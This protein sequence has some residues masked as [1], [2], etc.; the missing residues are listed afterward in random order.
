MPQTNNLEPIRQRPD[1]SWQHFFV[2]Q[3]VYDLL[4]AL[5]NYFK[6]EIVIKGINVTDIYAV[7]SLFSAVIES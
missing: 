4:E 5:P 6:S 7:G 1:T 2:W 3:K